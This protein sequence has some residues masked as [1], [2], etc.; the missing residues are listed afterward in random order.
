MDAEGA[1]AALLR[2]IDEM[3]KIHD[4]KQIHERRL[5]ARYMVERDAVALIG[6]SAHLADTDEYQ[7]RL[8][9]CPARARRRIRS[10]GAGAIAVKSFESGYLAAMPISH[11]LLRVVREVSEYRGKQELYQRQF[12]QVLESLRQVAMVQSTESSNRIEGVTAPVERIRSLVARKTT[13]RNR[14]EQEIAGYRDVLSTIHASAADIPFTANVVLQL[15]RDLFQFLPGEGGYWKRA[16]NEIVETRPDGTKVVR[17]RPVGAHLTVAA[18]ERLHES[19]TAHWEE[20][21]IERLVLIAAYVLDFLCIHPF[22]DG[23][24]RM[25]RLLTTLLLYQAGYD[26]VTYVSLGANRGAHQGELA[27]TRYIGLPSTGMRAA[28]ISRPGSS[29]CLGSSCSAAARSSNAGSEWST[30]G[31]APRRRWCGTPSPTSSANS[32]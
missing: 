7:W 27:T 10:S 4:Q 16:D 3:A 9:N 14:S 15:H 5:L 13:P 2:K 19:L 25:A 6:R 23:N 26:V 31:G 11:R 12:P 1:L 24:G 30:V 20:E 17:F 32:R 29:T 8:R 22:R 21:A 18:M 28:T